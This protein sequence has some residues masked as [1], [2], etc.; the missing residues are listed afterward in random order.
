VA[1]AARDRVSDMLDHELEALDAEWSGEGQSEAASEDQVR[2]NRQ[3]IVRA[4]TATAEARDRAASDRR[5][6]AEDRSRAAEDRREG[7]LEREA[8]LARVAAAETDALTGAQARAPGL[9]E[10]EHEVD[11]ARRT[12]GVLAIAYVDVVGLKRVNDTRG[13]AAGDALLKDV[14]GVLRAHLRSYDAIV[15]VGGDEFVCVMSGAPIESA[16]QR[17][18]SIKASTDESGCAIKFGVAGLDGEDDVPALVDRA[19]HAMPARPSRT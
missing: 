6:A 10:L 14:V 19:D 1:A 13:H 7:L 12:T 9:E 16:R 11:R 15:R 4:R 3:R 18:A 17:F 8:L 2:A 5:E